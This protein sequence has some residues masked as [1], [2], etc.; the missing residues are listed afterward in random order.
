MIAHGRGIM[1]DFQ[2]SMLLR[3][4][5]DANTYNKMQP[6]FPSWSITQLGKRSHWRYEAYAGASSV[7]KQFSIQ[8]SRLSNATKLLFVFTEVECLLQEVRSLVLSL[9]GLGFS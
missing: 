8:F 9:I 2:A 5:C 3:N 6:R 1:A 4:Q 7:I